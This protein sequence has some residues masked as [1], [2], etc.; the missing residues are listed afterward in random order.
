MEKIINNNLNGYPEIRNILCDKSNMY[1]EKK[2]LFNYGLKLAHILSGKGY[3]PFWKG[4][5][6]NPFT[7]KTPCHFFN[8]INLGNNPFKVH[9]E[10]TIPRLGNMP[11]WL[12][13]LG[14]KKLAAANCKEIIA[15][16]QCAY[17]LQID[18]LQKEYPQYIKA[19]QK[20][21]KVQLPPQLT[22][23]DDYS[24]KKLP[25]DK[26]AFTLV[27]GDFFRKGGAEI[28]TV[29]NRL[30]PKHPELFLN[31]VSSLNYGDYATHTTIEDK[32]K[33]IKLINKYPDNIK[34]YSSLPNYKVLELVKDSHVGLLPTW[35]DSFGY[36]VL[37]AQAAGCPV[38][39]TDIRAL[40]E[41]NNNELGWIIPLYGA[42]H[43][44]QTSNSLTEQLKKI[45]Q[46]IIQAGVNEI[47]R[48][49]EKA[50][51]NIKLKHSY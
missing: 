15:I 18:Y 43:N 13:T 24:E 7:N 36:S 17:D 4:F 37:E 5:F 39:T 21:M 11:R 25:K 16:S 27:G 26:I 46:E 51:E 40:P 20:K 33:A 32:K 3:H 14:V 9:F 48:K 42:G 31:I 50:L 12:Y 22:L 44:K 41:V 2:D 29:F 6:F 30:I 1:I 34:H 38:I 35:A 45:I 8:T 47:K 49:G 28:L 19:I 23:I 10:T